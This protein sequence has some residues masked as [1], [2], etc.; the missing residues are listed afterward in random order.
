MLKRLFHRLLPYRR[1][2]LTI[3]LGL[4]LEMGFNGLLPLSLRFLIDRALID[5]TA[6]DRDPRAIAG[7]LVFLGF[8]AIVASVA[9]LLR[10]RA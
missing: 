9:G 4:L 7:L 8:G 5:D 3:F 2:L 1:P 10:D 6:A